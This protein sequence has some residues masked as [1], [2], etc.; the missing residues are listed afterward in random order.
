MLSSHYLSIRL[1]AAI[2]L[3]HRDYPRPTIFNLN[4]SYKQGEPTFPNPGISTPPSEGRFS[5]SQYVS[6]PRPL[7][8][9]KPLPQLAK[10]DPATFSY[11]IEGVTLLAYDIAWLCSTQGVPIGDKTY[12]DDICNMGRNLYSL[13]I[14]QQTNSGSMFPVPSAPQ[15]TNEDAGD[16]TGQA[17]WM[18]RFSHGATYYFLCGAEGSEFTKNFKLP[19]PMKLADKLKKKLVTDA[20]IPDWEMLD[21]DAWKVEDDPNKENNA[22]KDVLAEGKSSPHRGSS[23]WMK[24]KNR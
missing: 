8:V 10:E 24:V 22:T 2:T 13:L 14:T 3:P 21:D 23:G 9:D 17:N 16:K 15:S 7:F 11:F 18:G 12:F 19:S 6:R 5:G 1:P 4:N 20:P